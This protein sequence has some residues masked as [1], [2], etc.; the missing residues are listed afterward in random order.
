MQS[1][2]TWDDS[3]NVMLMAVT[4]AVLVAVAGCEDAGGL[5]A[6]ETGTV[7]GKVT[8]QNKPI[9]AG[10]TVIFVN[11]KHGIAATGTVSAGGEYTLQMRG[12]PDILVGEYKVSVTPPPSAQPKMSDEEAMKASMEGTLPE[13]KEVTAFPKKYTVP[14]TSGLTVSVKAGENS[15]V[16]F[17]L[18]D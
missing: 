14:E 6:G 3:W 7:K 18:K 17:D 5:P 4:V 16:N 15:G 9:P 13:A 1:H 12:G 11:E 8:Y 2:N 10:A